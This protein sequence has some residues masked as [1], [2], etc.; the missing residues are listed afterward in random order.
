MRNL[1]I[2]EGHFIE[3]YA[4]YQQV[5]LSGQFA[6]IGILVCSILAG[7]E[8]VQGNFSAVLV[9]GIAN[10]FLVACLALHRA[11]RY[12]LAHYF[13][14][15]PVNLTAYLLAS[16]E[17]VATG[18]SVHF[19]S[20]ALAAFIVFGY[21]HW[22][23]AVTFA[24]LTFLLLTLAYFVDFSIL[25]FRHY[26]EELMLYMRLI[27]FII[28][29]LVCIAGVFMLIR[30]NH[31]NSVKL[32]ENYKLLTK[33]NTE[34][35]RFV[36]STSH[37]LRA[38]LT[39]ILGLIN[40]ADLS[41]N[42]GDMK[43]YLGMMK[44]RVLLL[45]KFIKDITDYS[46]NN[47]VDIERQKINLAKVSQEV[48][49][50]LKYTPEAQQVTFQL[51]IPEDVEIESDENRLK[52]VLLNLI[53]NAIRYQDKKKND[54]YVRLRYQMNGKGYHI[55]VEDNGQGIEPAYHSKIFDMFFR[56]NETSKGSGLGL[57]IVKETISKLSGT[58]QLESAP[59]VGST[60]T[61]KLPYRN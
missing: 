50:L 5:I 39:S 33:V 21:Q 26:D 40:I 8:L 25:P 48:W 11:G 28:A 58:I 43:R 37:D 6:L 52:T 27:N 20:I 17:D 61:L 41:N 9:F 4:E 31:K 56:A 22:K 18:A 45:D 51:E 35:D 3:L 49:D 46:R 10:L 30:L 59:G 32:V 24:S 53:S 44:D 57:Y 7:I 54:K 13:L 36:Y 19:I 34:L 47:R 15:I 29:S 42:Q 2:G 14:L 60:F 55:K 23:C 16:S 1:I 12:N 38:P